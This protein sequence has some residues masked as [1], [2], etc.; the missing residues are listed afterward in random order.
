MAIRHYKREVAHS[1]PKERWSEKQK[2]EA[3]ALYKLL[4]SLTE[5][6]KQLMIPL[7]TIKRWHISDW[8]KDYELEVAQAGRAGL[9]GKLSKI[10]DRA[11]TIVE[12][13]LENGDLVVNQKTGELVRRPVN[14]VV[15]NKIMTDTI[16]RAVLIEKLNTEHKQTITTEKITDRLLHLAEFFKKGGQKREVGEV[17]DV[18]PIVENEDGE[19][20]PLE[21]QSTD[22]QPSSVGL[23]TGQESP[24]Q[25]E[26]AASQP[27]PEGEIG[28]SP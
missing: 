13:R 25:S 20:T 15:A 10:R 5:T 23:S 12:D 26:T 2:Y 18:E 17:I 1:S 3:V 24:L 14:V 27:V 28:V 21:D 19:S 16:D 6:A 7:D 4:G 11:I 22:N 9:T 8:W